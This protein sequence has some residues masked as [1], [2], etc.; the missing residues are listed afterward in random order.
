MS[1]FIDADSLIKK[2]ERRYEEMRLKYGEYDQFNMGFVEG[3]VAID[4]AP[5]LDV[6]RVVKCKDC[7]HAKFNDYEG[8]YECGRL[9]L[10]VNR[11]FYC[12]Y[13]IRRPND[14]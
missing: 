7:L 5:T 11:E 8:V 14:D 6:V 10:F 3:M 13:G 9:K 2:M 12:F 1:R 4:N